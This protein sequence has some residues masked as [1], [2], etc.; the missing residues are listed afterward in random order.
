MA[1][2]RRQ[3]EFISGALP[4]GDAHAF[5]QK[6]KRPRS[7]PPAAQ[8]DGQLA[9]SMREIVL[10]TSGNAY[11]STCGPLRTTKEF[12][13]ACCEATFVLLGLEPPCRGQ[14]SQVGRH[15]GIH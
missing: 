2:Q 8:K 11:G 6:S 10:K 7:F 15:V 4:L 12:A 13:T 14:P 9:Q 5:G 1:H 3:R